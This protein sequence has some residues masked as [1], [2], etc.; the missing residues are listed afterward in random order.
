[1]RIKE[2][3]KEKGLTVG[4]VATR[5]GVAPQ[6]L[7]RVINGNPTVEMVERVAEAIGVSPAELFEKPSDGGFTCP[8]CG[9]TFHVDIRMT[10]EP[11]IPDHENIRGEDYYK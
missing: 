4:A 7:S 3:I 5:M 8:N 6:A 2:V 1:M 11:K 9:S 10:G